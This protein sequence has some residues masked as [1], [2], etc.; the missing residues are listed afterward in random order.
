MFLFI[1]FAPDKQFTSV[2][3]P[4]QGCYTQ[5]AAR[6]PAR[7]VG[8]KAAYLGFCFGFSP[9]GDPGPG[10]SATRSPGKSNVS[11]ICG[12]PSH[13]PGL[14]GACKAAPSSRVPGD[15]LFIPTCGTRYGRRICKLAIE[16]HEG[17]IVRKSPWPGYEDGV[18]TS[19][20]SPPVSR[21]CQPHESAYHVKG[22]STESIQP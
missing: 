22:C 5:G 10:R 16:A 6:N 21:T 11:S 9:T 1:L 8:I 2:F 13:P 12:S 17:S 20:I 14:S 18:C 19:A 4:D 3:S 7:A 15:F